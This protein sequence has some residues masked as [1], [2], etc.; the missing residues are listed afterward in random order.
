MTSLRIIERQFLARQAAEKAKAEPDLAAMIRRAIA[1]ALAEAGVAARTPAPQPPEPPRASRWT[2]PARTYAPPPDHPLQA[3][4]EPLAPLPLE[5]PASPAAP[6][7]IPKQLKIERDYL[8][9]V[10]ALRAEPGGPTFSVRRDELGKIDLVLIDGTPHNR[11]LYGVDGETVVASVPA[12]DRPAT[13]YDGRPVPPAS[14][15][16]RST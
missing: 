5:V 3:R 6:R 12:G 9:R 7:P 8:G 2:R 1:D 10:K 14:S 13:R 15:N 4:T 11:W 16:T